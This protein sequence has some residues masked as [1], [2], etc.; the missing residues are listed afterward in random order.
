M[1]NSILIILLCGIL[2]L[3][4]DP[5]P[6]F[7]LRDVDGI[8][9]VT[10]VKS[11]SGGTCWTH[12]AMAAMEGNLMMTGAWT[13]AGEEGMPDLAEY[14]LDW[15]NGFNEYHNADIDPPSGSGLVVHQGGDYMV[16]SA[17]LSRGDGA[18][19]D[20]DGQSFDSPPD[21]TNPGYHYYYAPEIQWLTAGANLENLDDIKNV[22]IDYG[23]LGTCMAYNNAFI[24]LGEYTHYQPPSSDMLPN[25][26]VSIV[27]WDD[28]KQ[29]QAPQ[30]GAWLV[31][32]SWGAGWGLD[33]YFWISYY[34]KWSCQEPEMGAVSFQNV[35]PMQWDNFYYHDYH[36][37]RDTR[38]EISEA[39][40][41]FTAQGPEVL[42]AV[43]FFT[44]VDN[45]D[46]TVT[47]YDSFTGGSLQTPLAA[48]SG[49]YERTGFHT[50]E[51]DPAVSLAEGQ[52]FYIYL[53]LS[54]GGHPYDRTS[55]VPVLLGASYRVL[56]ESSASAG[57][58]WYRENGQWL[59]FIN[60]D[61]GNWS[62]SGNFCIKGLSV[63]SSTGNPAPTGL[64]GTIEHVHDVVLTWDLPNSQRE[65]E[66]FRVFRDGEQL[67][68]ISAIP[69]VEMIYTDEDLDGGTYEYTV[70]AVYTEGA[71][72]HSAPVSVEVVLTAP[73]DLEAMVT[74]S[75][76]LLL[77]E[78]E[79]RDF[80]TLRIYRDD[81]PVHETN[82][83]FWV[84][85]TVTAGETYTYY[86][87]AV[88]PPYESEPSN[89]VTLL[90]TSAGDAPQ[91]PLTTTLRGNHPNPFNPETTITF[92][93]SQRQAVRLDIY[94]VRGRKVRTLVDG[95]R[96]YGMHEIVWNGKNDR[97]L[98]LGSGVYLIR[99]VSDSITETQRIILMK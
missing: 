22:I 39:F 26:A 95:V 45:V 30:P 46:F 32:N 88:Y 92:S 76:V 85:N 31:K 34:D 55:E 78:F 24:D 42:N 94:D 38:P 20:Q 58:S 97:G 74:G 44:A 7:D 70:Q 66:A 12:G 59:D 56:V 4:S 71:S 80:F 37:W 50:V 25:H 43:S 72:Q 15:W 8:N 65:L 67:A 90:V 52:D 69:W 11:Q 68:E 61:D 48:V 33:G 6:Q 19:R 62:G 27:G 79:T 73:Y 82:G 41:A 13:Q 51:L 86:M 18:V 35:I 10:S 99:F 63:N 3:Q 91:V 28:S 98:S 47:V 57:E 40:N 93:L 17:Y 49:N 89:S 96:E 81:Q 21:Y 75:N 29:T 14:H 2:F 53:Q 5:P 64:N 1:R 84:D 83:T 23:V 9:Y 36:G 54:D 87:T 60:F 77:W 16:T